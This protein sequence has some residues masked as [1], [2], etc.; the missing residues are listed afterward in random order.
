MN[1][2]IQLHLPKVLRS[3]QFFFAFLCKTALS[4]QSRAHFADLIFQNFSERLSFERFLCKSSS[5]YSP[6]RFLP[7]SSSKS[8]L[9]CKSSSCHSPVHDLSGAFLDPGPHPGNS[10]PTSATT[11]ATLPKKT[12]GLAPESVF[13]RE[14]IHTL[15]NCHSSQLLGDDVVDMMMWL[16]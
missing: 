10:D 12:H 2:Y 6:V 7:T 1:R 16:T 3:P 9:K 11:E 13:T 8:V 4:L 5:H 14:L 15:P